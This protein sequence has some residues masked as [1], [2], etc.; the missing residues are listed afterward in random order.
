MPA[1]TDD[2]TATVN[3]IDTTDRGFI[4]AFEQGRIPPADFHHADHLRLALAYLRDSSSVTEA[5]D[6][7]AD[8]IRTFA[9]AA[10]HEEKYHHTM[11]VAWIRLVARLLDKELPLAYFSRGRLFSQEARERW[12]EPDIRPL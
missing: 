4:E 11:T 7:M 9:R 10:G 8:A 2:I 12:V 5:T 6:R 1:A 3:T